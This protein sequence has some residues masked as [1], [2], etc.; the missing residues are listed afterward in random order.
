MATEQQQ[1]LVGHVVIAVQGEDATV[2][3]FIGTRHGELAL[4]PAT[5]AADLEADALAVIRH[6][7][8]GSHPIMGGRYSCP[9]DLAARA[10]W[11]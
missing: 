5:N 1:R 6:K 9:A 2:C 10:T 11:E 7:G 4:Q 3:R 8:G